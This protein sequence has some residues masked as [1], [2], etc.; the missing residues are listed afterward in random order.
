MAT[1]SERLARLEEK[2]AALVERVTNQDAEFKRRLAELNGEHSRIADVVANT[3]SKEQAKS[4]LDKSFAK[5][6]ANDKVIHAKLEASEHSSDVRMQVLEDRGN[7]SKG[8][9]WLPR[10]VLGALAAG[11]GAYLASKFLH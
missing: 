6:D 8:E 5:I 3:Q 4:D 9:N 11:A 2:H 7:V 1:K 10:I